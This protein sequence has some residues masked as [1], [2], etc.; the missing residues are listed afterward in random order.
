MSIIEL[1]KKQKALDDSIHQIKNIEYD[2]NKVKLALYVELG[3][4]ANEWQEFKYWKEDKNS[5]RDKMLEEYAD[6]LHFCLS[7]ENYHYIQLDNSSIQEQYIEYYKKIPYLL[8]ILKIDEPIDLFLKM[9]TVEYSLLTLL[10]LGL[11]LGFSKEEI[12]KSY[13]AKHKINYER[14]KNNY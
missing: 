12:Q 10:Q 14:L 7:I 13:N 3:E 11:A 1:L 4:L 5:K 9:Y 8:D 2:I 6:C